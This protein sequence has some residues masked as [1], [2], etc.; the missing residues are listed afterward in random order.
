[1]L[2][3]WRTSSTSNRTARKAA[4]Q[5]LQQ[6]LEHHR[7]RLRSQPPFKFPSLFLFSEPT[8]RFRSLSS[9]SPSNLMRKK[10]PLY[11]AIAARFRLNISQYA[12]R[13]DGLTSTP[14]SRPS[15]NATIL[16]IKKDPSNEKPDSD[17]K[18]G[19]EGSVS[20]SATV[21]ESTKEPN[22]PRNP[23]ATVASVPFK[24]VNL[25]A[26][27][28]DP[29]Y[30]GQ[31]QQ[32]EDEIVINAS[33]IHSPIHSPRAHG[34][35]DQEMVSASA[36]DSS[37]S[38]SD[39]RESRD[40][41][42]KVGLPAGRVTRSQVVRQRITAPA[43]T[44]TRNP[45]PA[46]TTRREIDAHNGVVPPGR[47]DP[48][49]N[50]TNPLIM[51]EGRN[52]GRILHAG[53]SAEERALVRSLDKSDQRAQYMAVSSF[54]FGTQDEKI[55]TP[56]LKEFQKRT[57]IPKTRNIYKTICHLMNPEVG[58]K[59]FFQIYVERDWTIESTKKHQNAKQFLY[60]L[61]IQLSKTDLKQREEGLKNGSGKP[62]AMG[63]YWRN[64]CV[65]G[66]IPT[67]EELR[68]A[69]ESAAAKMGYQAAGAAG[70]ANAASMPAS[71]PHARTRFQSGSRS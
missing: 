36:Q 45:S 11:L 7:C 1:M 54:L 31:S 19:E 9:S 52:A 35:T 13:Q 23:D 66:H 70:G 14:D 40:K 34:G 21:A 4:P 33:P 27:L 63:A 51:P 25:C 12:P 39:N 10:A 41:S 20:N 60:E 42:K 71:N 37:S 69:A 47:P 64:S 62:T 68:A 44:S 49:L 18:E 58:W 46:Y 57:G 6:P 48:N 3:T 28:V 24:P 2:K 26:P 53:S 22:P 30:G 15:P 56:Q 61:A 38:D 29:N 55:Q 5:G 65:A 43:A 50:L 67:I 17:M 59:K 8:I 16:A 32:D